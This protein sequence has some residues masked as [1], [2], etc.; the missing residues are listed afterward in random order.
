MYSFNSVDPN[1]VTIKKAYTLQI[2]NTGV[3]LNKTS[4]TLKCSWI[5]GRRME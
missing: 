5:K 3:S 1:L 4:L 2:K